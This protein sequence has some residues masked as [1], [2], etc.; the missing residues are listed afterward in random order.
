V[1]AVVTAAA[2]SRP[3]GARS[4]VAAVIAD[5]ARALV[6]GR[7]S[8]HPALDALRAVAVLVVMA[9]H[10]PSR[11]QAGGGADVPAGR[12]GPFAMGFAGVDLFFVLSGFLIG[13]PLWRE[14][15]TS[16]TISFRQFFLRRT[17][18]IWPYYYFALLGWTL[19]HP[20][21]C[22]G[23]QLSELFFYANYTPLS[24]IPGSWSLSTE[25]QFYVVAPALLWLL[26]RRIPLWGYFAVFG[27]LEAVVIAARYREVAAIVA[28]GAK[29]HYFEQSH[30]HC[31][32]LL[33]GMALALVSTLRPAWFEPAAP[34]RAGR[35]RG[36]AVFAAGCVA[37]FGLYA[38]DRMVYNLLSLALI[39]ATL[40]YAL[41]TDASALRAVWRWRG[42][43]TISMLSFGMYL[44][45]FLF[46][47][48]FGHWWGGATHDVLAPN[49]AFFVGFVLAVVL[50]AALAAVTYLLVEHPFLVLRDRR[51]SPAP[52]AGGD[53]P[54]PSPLPPAARGDELAPALAPVVD[55]RP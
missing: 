38:L 50:C 30:L 32:G 45:Q 34:G 51:L 7:A 17:L 21:D 23:A 43:Q 5:G 40:T 41:L 27:G 53:F 55:R 13:R 6:A 15:A 44:N 26:G 8:R 36:W 47:T 18:R 19:W 24:G 29:F 25:E 3:A 35:L 1:S 16:G 2:S 22:P 39:F 11:F 9:Q 42:F 54:A 52:T 10:W 48:E 12:H 31:D 46:L 37:A 20:N 14:L 4:A 33:V 28:G 49:V